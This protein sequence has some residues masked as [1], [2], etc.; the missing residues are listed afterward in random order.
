MRAI[1]CVLILIVL[2]K[3]LLKQPTRIHKS[4]DRQPRLFQLMAST[5]EIADLKLTP[6]LQ[7]YATGLRNVPDDKL[8]Y[9][10]LLFLAAKCKPMA[11]ELKIESNKVPGCL[12][13]VYV[14]A[15]ID[16]ETQQIT[17]V[18]DSDA[19][20]TKG[21]VAMLVNGLSGHPYAVIKEVKPEFIQYAGIANSLT[22]GRNNGFLNMMRLMKI[23]A[24]QLAE[25]IPSAGSDASSTTSQPALTA[26]GGPIARSIV[27]KLSLLK[28]KELVVENES[29]KHAGHAGMNGQV[30][31]ESHFNVRIIADCFDG[32]TL[33]LR[34]KMVYTLLAK[35]LGSD[36]SAGDLIHALSIYAKTPQEEAAM[37]K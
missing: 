7:T 27:E 32:M 34:H 18:G 37:K 12:S 19:Q 30:N 11:P 2:A 33:V 29:H 35:E 28:P 22:P 17:F 6:V 15:T 13:T 23:K 36:G 25:G 31:S 1:I 9:Q 10:Q 20:L 16:Q 24:Q 5:D 14:H 26:G 3:G 4:F 21:L 8:R